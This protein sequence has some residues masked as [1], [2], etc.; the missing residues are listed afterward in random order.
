MRRLRCT[1]SSLKPLIIIITP[2]ALLPLPLVIRKQEAEC[3]YI[4]ILMAVYWMT[5]VLP[6]SV[7]ALLPALLFPL[8]GIMKS[9]QVASVYFKDFHLLLLGVI[10]LATSIEKW[11]LHRRIA[12]RLVTGLG[13]NPGM[14]MLG[15]MVGCA[16]LSM[17]LSNTSTVAMVMPIVEAVIQQVLNASEEA[18]KDHKGALNGI[19]NP[20]LQLEDIEAQHDQ[21]EKIKSIEAGITEPVQTAPEETETVK[22]PPPYN[23]KYRTREDHMMCKGLSL[24]IAYSSS[25]GGLTTLSGTST[26]LIFAEYIY[27]YYPDCTVI[28]FGNWFVLCLPICIIMLILS[29]IFLHWMYLGSNFRASLCSK[30]RSEK[31][32]QTAK[33]LQDQYNSLGPISWQ[34]IIT[35]IV[36]I[37]MAVLWFTRNPGFMPGWSSLFPDYP[38]YATD[39]TVALLLGFTFFI[40]PA[41]K[42]NTERYEALITW[43]DFQACMPWEIS[44]LVGGGFALAEGTKISGLSTWVA[45]L[46][47]PLGSLPP[48]ATVTIASLIVT[49]ITEV[50]SNA[51]TMTIFLPILAPLAEA[52]G[53][54][55]LYMLIP[56]ALCVSFSFLLPVSNPPNAI[57]FTYGHLTSMDMVKAGLGVNVI[58]VLT[59]L[60]ALTTWATPLLN[61]DTYPDWAPVVNVTG[62]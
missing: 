10:C 27:Q 32:K 33:V 54:N 30:Q 26:N 44:L 9:S 3:A 40:I 18:S 35:M 34:E 41:H 50:A 52:I 1:W 51:A 61:L 60:L 16:F 55:P 37:L 12:L 19:S 5:E 28:N 20:A 4:L 46:L 8:F 47:T 49:S 13:V 48:L 11:G 17:W 57:V 58:G 15:F 22:A 42:P 59:V 38:G 24:C 56:T 45:E 2:L 23:G 21:S 43:K 29:W 7:T 62:V 31:E 14:L 53:V 36:F 39:A 25:I 6:L